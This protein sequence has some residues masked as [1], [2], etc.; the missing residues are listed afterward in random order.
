MHHPKTSSSGDCVLGL[1]PYPNDER[2]YFR[3]QRRL[4]R[5]PQYA[6]SACG[7]HSE[8]G[9]KGDNSLGSTGV[10][11]Q[12]RERRMSCFP[13]PGEPCY[14]RLRWPSR[15]KM[16]SLALGLDGHLASHFLADI[17]AKESI[18]HEL[19]QPQ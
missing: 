19:S 16:N 18:G 9:W 14:G 5:E 8:C 11:K 10:R 15:L 12:D 7:A 6:R 2:A 17:R 3:R 13:L 4:Y 1:A